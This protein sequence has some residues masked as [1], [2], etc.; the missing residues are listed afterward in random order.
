MPKKANFPDK[1]TIVLSSPSSIVAN[2][3]VRNIIPPPQFHTLKKKI[4]IQSNYFG[5]CCA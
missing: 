1:D 5:R 4:Q 2:G 3:T